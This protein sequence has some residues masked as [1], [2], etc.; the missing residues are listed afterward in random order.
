MFRGDLY[1]Y[2][3]Y[4]QKHLLLE[5]NVKFMY[6]DVACK[7]S[8]WLKRVDPEVAQKMCLAIGAMHIKKHKSSC[9]VISY[10]QGVFLIPLESEL[11]CSLSPIDLLYIAFQLLF[12]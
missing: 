3:L 7:Y 8:T 10:L 1:G 4:L 9:Q 6:I 5:N 11:P 12:F 2:S